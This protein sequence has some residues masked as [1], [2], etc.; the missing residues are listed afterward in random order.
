MLPHT[1]LWRLLQCRPA[2]IQNAPTCD[3][4]SISCP[5]ISPAQRSCHRTCHLLSSNPLLPQEFRHS[6]H[7]PNPVETPPCVGARCT[8]TN[9]DRCIRVSR[10]SN[11]HTQFY[12][13]HRPP[14]FYILEA[15]IQMNAVKVMCKPVPGVAS[16]QAWDAPRRSSAPVIPYCATFQLNLMIYWSAN[17]FAEDESARIFPPQQIEFIS[18]TCCGVW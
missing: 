11:R 16:S 10:I 12:L 18:S 17:Y 4:W 2:R 7:L 9:Q 5:S 15:I 8:R 6:Q 3:P 14:R 13:S 1:T